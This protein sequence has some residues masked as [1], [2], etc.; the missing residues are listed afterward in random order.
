MTMKVLLNLRYT[1][2]KNTQNQ[3]T[4]LIQYIEPII[5]NMNHPLNLYTMLLEV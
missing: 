5:H 3:E 4:K 1:Y 2:M